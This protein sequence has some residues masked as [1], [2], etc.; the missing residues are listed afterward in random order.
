MTEVT[1]GIGVKEGMNR[2]I[3]VERVSANLGERC[4]LFKKDIPLESV[5]QLK[6]IRRVNAISFYADLSKQNTV[7]CDVMWFANLG[8]LLHQSTVAVIR[9]LVT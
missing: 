6:L 5:G 4:V 3:L 2:G 9:T 1:V 8:V 7:R